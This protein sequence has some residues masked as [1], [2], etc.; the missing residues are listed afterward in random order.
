MGLAVV[1]IVPL[2]GEDDAV[3]FGLLELFRQTPPDML[4]I[5][6]IGVRRRRHLDKL[7]AA[8][9]KHVLLL[10]ALRLRNDD[11]RAI[12]ARIGDQ[13]KADAGIAGGRLDHQAARAQLAA[14]LSF[15]DH[16]PAGA[17]L[18]RTARVHELGLAE[19]GAAGRLGCAS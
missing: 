6:R 12:A 14:F 5:I 8:Q 9:P 17:V 2:V 19:D 7:G 15:K 10:L 11:Q 3:L 1:E 16:L 4:I 13:R 18:H